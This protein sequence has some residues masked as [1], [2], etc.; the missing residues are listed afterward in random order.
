MSYFEIYMPSASLY[1]ATEGVAIS[2]GMA[3][4]IIYLKSTFP[5]ADSS[6]IF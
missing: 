3:N 2:H 5:H 4:E 1:N 6:Q